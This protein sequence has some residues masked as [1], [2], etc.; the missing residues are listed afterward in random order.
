MQRSAAFQRSNVDVHAGMQQ[1]SY[2]FHKAFFWK[3]RTQ[4]ICERIDGDFLGI[5]PLFCSML[6]TS[7]FSSN[8]FDRS[9]IYLMQCGAETRRSSN[10]RRWK[11]IV[12]QNEFK[13]SFVLFFF[14][15]FLQ[16]IFSPPFFSSLYLLQYTEER[17]WSYRRS[18]DRRRRKLIPLEF[19]IFRAALLCAAERFFLC[20]KYSDPPL[21]WSVLVRF[22]CD[23][24]E[25]KKNWKIRS[26]ADERMLWER[27]R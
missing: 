18:I 13:I 19:P 17:S 9:I 5:S 1:F 20:R 23:L 3:K 27:K 4:K 2:T 14:S 24:K 6:W 22:Q 11:S 8:S 25:I 7:W 12:F 26:E 15:N 16:S 10:L 21:L